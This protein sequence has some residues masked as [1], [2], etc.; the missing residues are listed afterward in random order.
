MTTAELAA[1]YAN[2]LI[3]EYIGQPKA[4]ATV[5]AQVTP[6]LMDQMP[7]AVQNAFSVDTAVGVQLDVI[8]KYVGV[9]RVNY[10]S[11]TSVPIS[12]DDADF[13]TL[14]KMVI[15][16][17]NSGSSLATIQSLVAATFP[18]EIFVSDNADM[19]LNY[20]ILESLGSTNLLDVLQTGNYLPAPMAVQVSVT[21]VPDITHPFFG[22]ITYSSTPT[23][24]PFN[25]Y[26]FY[27][28]T[29][30]WLSYSS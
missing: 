14:I 23:V 13:R 6:A 25:N 21:I 24:S 30:P 9:T 17:N 18:G 29:Y 3:I 27:Q 28:L 2:L 10:P 4:Y 1:Y 26:E 16:K 7:D 20:V 22:F 8:G 19:G 11:S 5:L 12:L 15:I